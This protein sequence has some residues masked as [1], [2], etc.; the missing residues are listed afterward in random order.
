MRTVISISSPSMPA[1]GSPGPRRVVTPSRVRSTT[2]P[3]SNGKR[4]TP[5]MLRSTTT[6]YTPTTPFCASKA[7]MPSLEWS[8]LAGEPSVT[9]GTV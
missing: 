4:S 2:M 7:T 6:V 9:V 1:K 5:T 8:S 3:F